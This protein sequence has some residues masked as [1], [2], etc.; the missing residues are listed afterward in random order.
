MSKISVDYINSRYSSVEDYIYD[1]EKYS[2]E[3]KAVGDCIARSRNL[4][5]IILLSGPSGSG[6]TT[7]AKL[8][9]NYLDGIGVETHTVSLDNYFKTVGNETVDYESPTRINSELLTDNIEKLINCES[10]KLPVFD[11]LKNESRISDIQLKRKDGELIIFEGIHA[12]NP[13]VVKI[14][15]GTTKIFVDVSSEISYGNKVLGGKFVRLMRRIFRD[16]IYRARDFITTLN[17]FK[18]VEYGTEKYLLPYKNLADYN[19]DSFTPYEVALY[20][21]PLTVKLNEVM[22]NLQGENLSLAN[23]LKD[24]FGFVKERDFSSLPKSSII[25]EFIG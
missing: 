19:L 16:D 25:R 7:T 11:F 21:K 13:S 5:P 8:L 20:K 18:S 9:E 3:I 15:E 24:F 4:A 2:A 23:L 6:K 12:L 10:V 22:D 14:K 17:M 1:D